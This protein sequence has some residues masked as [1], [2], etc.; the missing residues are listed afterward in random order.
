MKD[1]EGQHGLIAVGQRLVVKIQIFR[2][3]AQNK[4]D[5]N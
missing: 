4:D 5:P 3:Q 1:I 2:A